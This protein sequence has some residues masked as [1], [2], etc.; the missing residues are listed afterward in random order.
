MVIAH[1]IILT[2]YGHWL[3]NDPRGSLS[4]EIRAGKLFALGSIHYGRK[5][6]QPERADLK[7]FYREAAAHL[8]HALL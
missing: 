2:A 5:S 6:M 4:Q 3:P 8:E 7:T 1:H